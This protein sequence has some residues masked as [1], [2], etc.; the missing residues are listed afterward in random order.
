MNRRFIIL[1][2]LMLAQT[3]HSRVLTVPAGFPSIRAAIEFSAEGD[4]VLVSYGEYTEN[5]AIDN[6]NISLLGA[7]IPESTIVRGYIII[8]GAEIDTTCLIQGVKFYNY[9]YGLDNNLVN[10]ID[11]SPKFQG[12]VVLGIWDMGNGYS[13][14]IR[15]ENSSA[16]IRSNKIQENRNYGHGWGIFAE[17]GYPI[18]ELNIISGNGGSNGGFGASGV[19][20]AID[21]GIVRRN[22]VSFNGASSAMSASGYGITTGAGPLIIENNT[23]YGNRAYSASYTEYGAGIAFGVTQG[24]QEKIIRNNIVV[25]NDPDGVHASI[26]DST[27]TGWD[28]NLVFGNI[29]TDY[30]GIDPGPHDLQADPLLNGFRLRPNSPCIDAGDP[31]SPLDPDGTRADIGAYY[32]D[33]AVGIDEPGTSGPYNFSL[34][35]NYPNPFN[36]KTIISYNLD[37]SAQVS[38]LVY[39]ITGQLVKTLANG[40]M[41]TAGEHRVIWDGTDRNGE[42]VSTGIYFYELYVDEYKESKAMIFVK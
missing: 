16:I 36:A 35:Q 33:Q 11:A 37:K 21:A 32:F 28:Y 4:T 10:I 18:I 17:G 26:H 31:N 20:L 38:L 22:L 27:W 19:G 9:T 23:I 15:M 2:I 5:L 41:Q 6:K 13:G 24:G 3:G 29:G 40:Q 14:G 34:A 42:P 12:N 7:G 1:A 30:S 8:Q 25:Y 39:S